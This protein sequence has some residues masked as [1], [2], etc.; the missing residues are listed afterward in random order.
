[1]RFSKIF[2][3][4]WRDY[5]SNFKETAKFVF[6]FLGILT[7]VQIFL[8]HAI[9][10]SDY[11]NTFIT[12]DEPN[13]TAI[14]LTIFYIFAAF[15]VSIAIMFMQVFV[16]AGLTGAS[17]KKR[18]T[19]AQAIKM[20]K[21][22]YWKFFGLC[23]VM[24]LFLIGLFILLIIPGLIFMIYWAFAAYILFDKK[25][26]ITGSLKKSRLL[27]K[28]KWWRVFGNILLIF[29]IFGAIYIVLY[30]AG[31]N[32]SKSSFIELLIEKESIPRD[33]LVYSL[34][35]NIIYQFFTLFVTYPFA[36]FFYKNLYYDLKNKKE[37]KRTKW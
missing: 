37:Y 21:G 28:G 7:L 19:Y 17:L 29:L 6:V 18:F 14:L 34:V 30:F 31:L 22:N 2:G 15:I 16:M 20:A 3:K 11:F 25:T 12:T 32:V 8:G 36:I 4:T 10:S 27:V 33:M 35:F 26:K 9:I 5:K 13:L 24:G 23:L 1:M